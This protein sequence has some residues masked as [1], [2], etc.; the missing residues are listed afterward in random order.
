MIIRKLN[1]CECCQE[2]IVED[3]EKEGIELLEDPEFDKKDV[4]DELIQ[5][6]VGDEEEELSAKSA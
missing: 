5:E 2:N 4:E 3:Q 1:K 6:N